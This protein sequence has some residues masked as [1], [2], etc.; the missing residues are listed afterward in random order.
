MTKKYKISLNELAQ[1]IKEEVESQM[2][3]GYQIVPGR[4]HAMNIRH[5]NAIPADLS[6]K[7]AQI[8]IGAPVK[9]KQFQTEK[10]GLSL[11]TYEDQDFY[12]PSGNLGPKGA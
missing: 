9:L 5:V 3:S 12:V 7:P 2:N 1:M 11:V 10:P 4:D 6:G 8:Q